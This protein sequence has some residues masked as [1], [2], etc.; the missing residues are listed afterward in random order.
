MVDQAVLDKLEAGFSKVAGSDSKSLLKK[1]L[2]KEVFDQLKTKKTSFGSTLLDVIQSGVENLDSGVGIYAPD[3]DSYTVFADLFDPIIEDYH[4]GFKKTDKHPPKDFGDVDSLG[5]LDPAV[6]IEDCSLDAMKRT[7]FIITYRIKIDIANIFVNLFLFGNNYKT[8]IVINSYSFS[9]N[10]DVK[11]ETGFIFK[12]ILPKSY[13][14]Y[15]IEIRRM[16]PRQFLR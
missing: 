16:I 7:V 6:S 5:N 9:S 4:G 1:Y 11:K 15:Y 3:A 14:Y 10:Y 8:I 13:N 2:S 12:F